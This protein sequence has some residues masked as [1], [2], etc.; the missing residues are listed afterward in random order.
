MTEVLV[1]LAEVLSTL[2]VLTAAFLTISA[3]IPQNLP[4]SRNIWE[5]PITAPPTTRGAN[6]LNRKVA[7][8]V[9]VIKI[10][11]N[12][13]RVKNNLN[14]VEVKVIKIFNNLNLQG[15]KTNRTLA[16][17]G[18]RNAG[19]FPAIVR[20]FFPHTLPLPLLLP[21][22]KELVVVVPKKLKTP[23]LRTRRVKTNN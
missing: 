18:R 19:I 2:C 14:P 20:E 5:E 1:F 21:T 22:L 16:A 12:L 10:F 11:N 6:N 13:N 15:I 8:E 9:K 17:S 7:V 4:F 3:G 23:R